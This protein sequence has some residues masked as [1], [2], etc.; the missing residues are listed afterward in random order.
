LGTINEVWSMD[1]MYDQLADGRSIRTLNLIDDFNRE[2]L[3]IEVDFSLPSD[4]VVRALN[5]IIEHRGHPLAIRC[6]N[7]PEYVG[8]TLSRWAQQLG[9]RLEFIQP[10]KP[11]PNAYIERFNRTAMAAS[12]STSATQ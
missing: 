2:A 3:G 10:G 11:Q 9:I 6:D 5:R 12:V 4:R 7:G 1:F 8:S